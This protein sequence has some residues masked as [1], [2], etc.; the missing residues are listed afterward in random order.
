MCAELCAEDALAL[1]ELLTGIT[2]LAPTTECQVRIGAQ[3]EVLAIDARDIMLHH[4]AISPLSTPD[5]VQSVGVD[6]E[7][8]LPKLA[9]A[10]RLAACVGSVTL[11]L[12]PGACVVH[13]RTRHH[14]VAYTL[15][16]VPVRDL[17][18]M[19]GNCG[20]HTSSALAV[21]VRGARLVS[22]LDACAPL[23]TDAASGRDTLQIMLDSHKVL[24]RSAESCA[25]IACMETHAG[26]D[27]CIRV[28]AHL[29]HALACL[30]KTQDAPHVNLACVLGGLLRVATDNGVCAYTAYLPQVDDTPR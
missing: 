29:V 25:T 24:V 8:S 21:G 19:I 22:A 15:G 4:V 17:Y 14:T 27:A 11:A 30:A 3:L 2:R 5:I 13:A 23:D 26:A 10:L 1:S 18:G 28:S 6:V 9:R 16:C 12:V 20:A 7:V